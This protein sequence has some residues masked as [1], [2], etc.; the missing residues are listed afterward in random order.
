MGEVE[1][2]VASPEALAT[3]QDNV[4]R[5]MAMSDRLRT[6]AHEHDLAKARNGHR[7]E[8]AIRLVNE[9]KATREEHRELGRHVASGMSPVEEAEHGL[10]LETA[11]S[12]RAGL[13]VLAPAAANQAIGNAMADLRF[14][15]VPSLN[16][17]T[18]GDGLGVLVAVA[19]A[20]NLYAVATET[21]SDDGKAA[22]WGPLVESIMATS[23]AGFLA[24]QSIWDTLLTA[25]ATKLA[26][27]WQR[28]ALQAVHIRLGMLHVGLGG[29]SYF[30]GIIGYGLSTIKHGGELIDA[31]KTGNSAAATGAALSFVG[32]T[33]LTATSTYGTRQTFS[34]LAHVLNATPGEGRALA[35]ASSG[36]RL[37]SLFA[38]LN[39]FGLAFS[40]LELAG[41]W[42][43]NHY[44]LSE[45]DKWLLSTPWS[46]EPER[47][48]NLS[49]AEYEAALAAL[50]E[51][52]SIMPANEAGNGR[53]SDVILNIHNW[54]PTALNQ[55][56]ALAH[57][58]PH[59]LALSAW[60][61]QPARSGMFNRL[62]ETWVRSAASIIESMQ[63]L[64]T[65]GHLQLQF[66]VPQPVKTKY[67]KETRDLVVMVRLE[68]LGADG[69]Y[70]TH[71]HLLTL[72][73][74]PEFPVT[75]VS[76]SPND[77]PV[78]RPIRQPLTVLDLYS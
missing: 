3:F 41:T 55:D 38:R 49:L 2:R 64:N 5:L 26:E 7:S 18:L 36:T 10:K 32:S 12:G 71:D 8:A 21:F 17:N 14:G 66:T 50:A 59:R 40:V 61:V 42:L 9:F 62:P 11:E 73:P 19:Q 24:A 34:S 44:N 76:E 37:S 47:N 31:M 23:G 6:L 60:R 52:V 67:G 75:P 53:S 56:L 77:Q 33:G 16:V 1:F 68:T 57:K 70:R 39:L 43:Y 27:A 46:K 74:E 13:T 35:W 45:R 22:S 20:V 15:R 54:G 29:I 69:A 25:R 72:P 78:W 30:A 28:G 58:E 51:P 4:R 63:V 48:K 65:S